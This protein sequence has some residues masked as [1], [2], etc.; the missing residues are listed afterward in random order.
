MYQ[1]GDVRSALISAVQAL[2]HAKN[3]ID[4]V[5]KTPVSLS[6]S[7]CHFFFPKGKLIR[8]DLKDIIFF[9]V[10]FS[11]TYT[12]CATKLVQHFLKTVSSTQRSK[13]W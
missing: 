3:G 1:E 4:F 10:E 11:G 12:F 2:Y 9:N 7:H 5:S 8:F 13:D 6:I